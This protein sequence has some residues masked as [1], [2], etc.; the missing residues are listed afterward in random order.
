[1]KYIKALL[2][3]RVAAVTTGALIVVGLGATSGF[4]AAQI[5]SAQIKDETIQASDIHAGAVGSSEVSNGSLGL[6]DLSSAAQSGIQGPQGPQGIPGSQGNR[7]LRGKQGLPG[8]PGE[9]GVPG[10]QGEPGV[11]GPQGEPGAPGAKGDS[12]L[13]GAYYSVAYY[14]V[15][16]TNAGAIATVA[17]KVPTDVAISGGVQVLGLDATAKDRNTP[18]SSSFPGRMDWTTNTP[19]A[20][21]LDGWIVQFGGNAGAVS[22]TAPEKAKVWALCVPG[23]DIPV[24]QTYLQSE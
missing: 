14:D 2:S 24:Q 20:D 4:A 7:G 8:L 17:C 11:A 21:R 22:D 6:A 3:S 23:A 10:P 15:G 13:L 16:D 1:M 19:K 18:V 9:Q 5:T 12:G